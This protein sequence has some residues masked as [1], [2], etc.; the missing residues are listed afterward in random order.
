MQ[1]QQNEGEIINLFRIY[2]YFF[3]WNFQNHARMSF[4]NFSVLASMA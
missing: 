3:P 1:V 4:L 2:T